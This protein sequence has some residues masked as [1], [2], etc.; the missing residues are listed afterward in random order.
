KPKKLTNSSSVGTGKDSDSGSSK[1]EKSKIGAALQKCATTPKEDSGGPGEDVVGRKINVWWPMDEK[2]YP[3][4]VKSF[5]VVKKKHV[6]LY[7]DGDVEILR[8][9]KERWK[10]IESSKNP[11]HRAAALLVKEEDHLDRKGK[12]VEARSKLKIRTKH[13]CLK[14]KGVGPLET[15]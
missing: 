2:Y 15:V 1:K 8:L 5:D 3:G 6:I 7:D 13:L 10:L 4:T 9:D 11:A 14:R 12:K